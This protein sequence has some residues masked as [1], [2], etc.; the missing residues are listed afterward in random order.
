MSRAAG[1]GRPPSTAAFCCAGASP[2]SRPSVTT[3]TQRR[4]HARITLQEYVV[5]TISMFLR[6]GRGRLAMAGAAPL[7]W[8]SREAPMLFGI[9]DFGVVLVVAAAVLAV[10]SFLLDL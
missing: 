8:R 6:L 1:R 9:M 5:P 4:C 7:S 2:P 3:A 10:V